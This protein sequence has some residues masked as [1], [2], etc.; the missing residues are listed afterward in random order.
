MKATWSYKIW[1]IAYPIGMYYVVSSLVYFVLTLFMGSSNATYM[2]RQLICAMA[3]IPVVSSFY[4][5][6][7][8]IRETVY[9][10][11][12]P[13]SFH[14]VKTAVIC[15]FV[16]AMLGMAVNNLLAMTPLMQV[17][18]GFREANE[19]F[20]GGRMLYELL[21]SC[22]VVPIVEELLFRGVVYRRLQ[23]FLGDKRALV[24]SA[25][26]FGLLHF[27]LVQFLYAGI[28][29]LL[30]AVLVQKSGELSTAVLAHIAANTAAV[31]RQETGWFAFSY[32]PTIEGL[33]F[34]ALLLFAGLSVLWI[35]FFRKSRKNPRFL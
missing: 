14:Q 26:L 6:D 25:V 13:F 24:W 22:L 15:L 1:Q 7:S 21:G 10:K 28:L 33:G 19:A 3:T 5:E 35:A 29:G 12:Q 17:S 4:R 31:L 18:E 30:L 34:T 2:Q 8:R 9:G 32:Q 16:G 11:K 27:N 23:V 20:F